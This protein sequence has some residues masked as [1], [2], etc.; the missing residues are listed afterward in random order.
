MSLSRYFDRIA[1]VLSA[2]CLVHC[3]A[4]TFLVAVLPVA[5]L[6]FGDD[7]HFHWLMIWL[8]VPTSVAGL[9]LGYRY[10]GRFEIASLGA[11]GMAI[12]AVAAILGHDQW[13]EYLEI[14][15]S[16]AGSLLLAGAHWFNFNEV[17]SQHR[18]A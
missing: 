4:I 18:H 11:L 14:L 3:V 5:A 6:R 1:I 2:I 10:H 16:V 7:A 13:S 17:R 15:V 9:Y 8:V 12:L